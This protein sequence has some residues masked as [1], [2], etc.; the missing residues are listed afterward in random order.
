M[1]N[2][3]KCKMLTGVLIGKLPQEKVNKNTKSCVFSGWVAGRS[4]RGPRN[5]LLFLTAFS[6]VQYK[7][8]EFR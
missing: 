1:V 2:K 7:T 5:K 3:S 6:K 8:C 4:G